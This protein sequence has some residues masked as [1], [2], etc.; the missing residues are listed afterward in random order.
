MNDEEQKYVYIALVY[1]P[2]AVGEFTKI[3]TRYGYSHATFSFDENFESCHA[4]SRLQKD[5]AFIGGY[6]NE[7]KS[8]YI[9]DPDKEVKIDTIMYKIPAT[10]E[11]IENIKKFIDEIA[12]DKEY[13]YNLYSMCTLAAFRGFRTYKAMHCTEFIAQIMMRLSAV[14]MSRKWYRYL[15]KDINRDLEKYTM[16]K[17]LLDTK[18]VKRKENDFFFKEIDKK[19]YAKKRRYIFKELWYRL[20]FKKASPNYDYRK[21]RFED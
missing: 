17:G 2:S 1:I 6:I 3:C 8:H 20:I 9:Y 4:F 19:A 12:N 16:Y 7:N 5:T 10:D 21:T 13:L 11:E 15:P 14:N 18:S